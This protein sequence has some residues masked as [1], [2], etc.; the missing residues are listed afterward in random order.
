VPISGPPVTPN[1]IAWLEDGLRSLGGTGLAEG[2]KMSVILLVS[3]YVRNEATLAADLAAAAA[4]SGGGQLMPTWSQQLVRLTDAER[5]PALHAA[6]GS[7]VFDQDDDPDDEFVFGLERV[8]DGIEA[9]V[10]SRGS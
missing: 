9:L 8:L 3:G 2:E 1:Q 6:L 7:G 10:R 4:A 5:F